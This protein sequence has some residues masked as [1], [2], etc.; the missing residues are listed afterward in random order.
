M[1]GGKEGPVSRRVG[2]SC[3]LNPGDSLGGRELI[4]AVM[5]EWF[6][7]HGIDAELVHHSPILTSASFARQ[8]GCP[9]E[10]V[11]LRYVDKAPSLIA[12]CRR[13]LGR[14]WERSLSSDYDL[15]INLVH[16]SPVMCYAPR[17]LLMVLFP[18]FQPAKWWPALRDY[19]FGFCWALLAFHQWRGRLHLRRH[20]RSYDKVTA[21]S[22]FAQAWTKKR[23]QVESE[24][25]YPPAEFSQAEAVVAQKRNLILSVGRFSVAGVRKR[26]LEMMQAFGALSLAERQDWKFVCAGAV[27][28]SER[29]KQFFDLV[30]S[31][32]ANAGGEAAGNVSRPELRSLY[33]SAAIFWHA[34][35]FGEDL[36]DRPELAEHYGISTVEAMF[37]GCVP[38]VINAG[39]QPE[40]VEHGVSGFLW[41]SIEELQRYTLCL[42]RDPYLRMKMAKAAQERA[43]FFSRIEF[44]RRFERTLEKIFGRDDPASSVARPHL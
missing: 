36:E 29:A 10:A 44:E 1:I 33:H 20:L 27:G 37:A 43:C 34:A 9:S 30:K 13:N 5:L 6:Y 40:L 32:G 19:P 22:Q 31:A 11:R 15:F 2:I 17:G 28:T 21:I 42:T 16:T 12:W 38:V 7:H 23:W 35:G 8:F 4:V 26:Q 24:I 39:A 14:R 3:E 25:V 41:N 18:F